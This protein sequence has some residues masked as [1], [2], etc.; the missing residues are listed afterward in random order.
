MTH[1]KKRIFFRVDG[2]QGNYAG[3]GHIYRSLKIYFYLKKKFKKTHNFFFISKN[4]T[5]G[6]RIL[7]KKTNEKIFLYNDKFIKDFKF[8]KKDLILIDTLGA[9]K[10]F[11]KKLNIAK[12]NKIVSFD[13]LNTKLF[14]KGIIINGIYFAKKILAPKNKKIRIFQGIKYILLDDDFKKKKYIGHN[15]NILVTSGGADKKNFLYKVSK[16]LLKQELKDSKIFVLIGNAVKKDNLVFK[17]K[18]KKN[19]YLVSNVEKIKKY[20]DL[21]SVVITSG[22]TVMFESISAG[23]ITFVIKTYEH[24]KYAINYFQKL[25]LITKF[26]YLK[27]LDTNKLINKIKFVYKN[28]EISKK[29]FKKNISFIDGKGFDRTKKILI[30][31]IDL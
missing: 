22:G 30:N 9:E 27:N 10:K 3:L 25:N 14:K 4:Y 16:I 26:T 20:L 15:N 11:I 31:Y 2:D 12:I 8:E 6:L 23:R 19:L 13:E 18:D 1:K 5:A 17:L 21:C 24:Q 7:K 29:Q 28:K